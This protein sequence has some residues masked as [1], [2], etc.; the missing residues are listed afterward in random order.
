VGE[1]ARD[2]RQRRVGTLE[3]LPQL[4]AADVSPEE[5]SSV[6][7]RL[8]L[9]PRGFSAASARSRSTMVAKRPAPP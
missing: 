5:I 1:L 2:A 9:R 6:P 3:D 7:V 8:G 4:L